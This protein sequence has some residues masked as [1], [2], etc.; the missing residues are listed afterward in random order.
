MLQEFQFESR[1]NFQPQLIR[2]PWRSTTSAANATRSPGQEIDEDFENMSDDVRDLEQVLSQ[3][4]DRSFSS[5][6]GKMYNCLLGTT[7]WSPFRLRCRAITLFRIFSLLFAAIMLGFTIAIAVTGNYHMDAYTLWSWTM[8]FV[9]S[10]F[11]A[12]TTFIESFWLILVVLFMLPVVW[13]NVVTVCFAI[14]IILAN[15]AELLIQDTKCGDNPPANPTSMST[16]HTGDWLE[17]GWPVFGMLV[18]ALSGLEFFWRF[19]LVKTLARWSAIGQWLYFAFWML[20][21]LVPIL[22]Y[23]LSFDVDKKYPTSFT[24]IERALILV[25]TMWI[26]MF[27][28]WLF[29][30]AKPRYEQLNVRWLDW[31]LSRMSKKELDM[32]TPEQLQLR[33]AI[34]AGPILVNI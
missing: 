32:M 5:D 21:P 4:L 34:L 33:A 16:I 29:A 22:I 7:F 1:T 31:R 11:L 6:A 12:L 19:I 24:W 8:L 23:D 18:L 15:N 28:S 3:D 2:T 17:H 27:V 26:W 13:G 30:I 20:A 9:F 25:G 10:V 14:I